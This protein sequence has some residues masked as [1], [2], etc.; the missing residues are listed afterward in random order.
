MS[1]YQKLNLSDQE[2]EYLQNHYNPQTKLSALCTQGPSLSSR[3]DAQTYPILEP[4]L[5]PQLLSSTHQESATGSNRF[6]VP[7]TDV[8]AVQASAV[9]K[10]TSK[11]TSW[12]VNIW[13]EWTTHRRTVCH[14]L[15]CPPHILL[16]QPEELNQWL[17]KFVLE[18]R[19][20]DGQQY[21][22]QTLYAICCGLLR[23]VRE[24]K[25]DIN[26]FKD[27]QFS[28]F[29]RTLDGEM[30][31]LRSCGLGSKKQAEPISIHEETILWEHGLLGSCSPQV[32]L[33]TMVFLCGMY[34]ALRSGQEHRDLQ[35]SQIE[36]IEPSGNSPP[37]L[38]YT[39][40]ISKNN[41]G[42]MAQRKLQ[43]K[44]VMHHSNTSNQ[45][46]CFV[47]LFKEYVQHCPKERK[48]TCFYLT[49]L[50]KPK[51][52]V[53]Y[54]DTPVGHNTLSKTVKRLCASVAD[55]GGGARG[56]GAPPPSG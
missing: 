37:Y 21:P 7:K 23:Y 14:P 20:K 45:S 47:H 31:H 27:A 16:C 6:S 8:Q 19:R 43:P 13:K 49:A 5:Q 46:R 32:L 4:R 34:F 39:E 53:W 25:P 17:S 38:V 50:K 22:P 1:R 30:K 26:F 2:L 24:L 28:G 3:T 52:Y 11:S 10:N 44:Q 9:P 36:L 54:S 35:F 55:P 56:A 18:I 51:G 15:D 40:N 42:G 41:T 29:Q 48:T 12:A 33:D